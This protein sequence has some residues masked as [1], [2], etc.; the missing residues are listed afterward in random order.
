MP[1]EREVSMEQFG[2]HLREVQVGRR[3]DEVIVH[4]TWRPSASDYRGIETV[5]AVRRYHTGVRGWSDNGYHVMIGP[6]GSIFLCR[7]LHRSGAHTAGRNAHSV[8]VS[9]I[10]NFDHDD[11]EHY[12]GLTTGHEVVA[13]L[14][15]RFDLGTAAIRFHREFAPKTCPG[16]KLG[17]SAF[18][19][20][21]AQAGARAAG[22]RP[23]IVLLP[24]SELVSC[25]ARIEDGVTRVDL[26][27]LVEAL[28]Y[29][30]HNHLRDQGKLYLAR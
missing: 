3:I 6:D 14:L 11:P 29:R 8:G 17:L 16:L 5:R 21:V 18:R 22:Q 4:H 30:I 10:A 13:A 24:G 26:R 25:N 15:E 12:Q 27:P 19:E 20:A 23:K 9:F 1:V 7:P 28:G 2:A